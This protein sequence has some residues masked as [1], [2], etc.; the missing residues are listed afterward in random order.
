MEGELDAL[1]ATVKGVDNVVA[2]A[3]SSITSN[4]IKDAVKRGVQKFTLCFDREPDREE[5]TNK[6]I[7]NAIDIIL[8]EDV[9][10]VYIATLPD[11]GGKTDVDRLIKEQE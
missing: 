9:Y 4:Q 11:L 2:M 7:N 3:G 1:F 8:N 10:K 5:E 6:K